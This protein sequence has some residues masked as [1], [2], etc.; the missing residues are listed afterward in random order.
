[1]GLAVAIQVRLQ[2]ERWIV[3]AEFESCAFELFEFELVKLNQDG[4]AKE[5]A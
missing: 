3:G 1:M 2:C 4:K 5:K